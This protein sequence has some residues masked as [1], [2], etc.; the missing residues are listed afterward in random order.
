[1]VCHSTAK[2]FHVAAELSSTCQNASSLRTHDAYCKLL[3]NHTTSLPIRYCVRWRISVQIP[4]YRLPDGGVLPHRDVH[5]VPIDVLGHLPSNRERETERGLQVGG[6]TEERKGVREGGQTPIQGDLQHIEIPSLSSRTWNIKFVFEDV[7][8]GIWE[9][10]RPT[11]VYTCTCGLQQFSPP[12]NRR[13]AGRWY[14]WWYR[15]CR[16][17]GWHRRCC[18]RPAPLPGSPLQI[19]HQVLGAQFSGGHL[20]VAEPP[21]SP[22]TTPT[23]GITAPF[24]QQWGRL[25]V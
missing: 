7:E 21:A 6:I 22:C 14:E 4:F 15:R 3:L 19:A 8:T 13:R 11:R 24:A 5:Q 20:A 18:A 17:R 9:T 23:R 16:W 25:R 1:M 12:A 10:F 2:P